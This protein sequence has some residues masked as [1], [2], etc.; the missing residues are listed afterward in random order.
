MRPLGGAVARALRALGIDRDVARASALDAWSA[1][2]AAE[3][4][5][6]AARTRAVRVEAETLVVAVPTAQWAVEIRLRE[7]ALVARL[8][9]VA[10]QSGVKRIRSVPGHVAAGDA[11]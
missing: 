4:G 6:D 9:S 3:I 5:A 1:V 2:A 7:R 10:P 8:R 11:Q